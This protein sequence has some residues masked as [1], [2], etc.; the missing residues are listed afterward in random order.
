MRKILVL[1]ATVLLFSFSACGGGGVKDNTKDRD[2]KTEREE[3]KKGNDSGS[4][5]QEASNLPRFDY[6]FNKEPIEF[7]TVD[8]LLNSA[9]VYA[10]VTYTP[11]MF[12][13][14]YRLENE[15]EQLEKYMAEMDYMEYANAGYGEITSIP[16]RMEIGPKNYNHMIQY[17]SEY[18]WARI[19]FMNGGGN[20]ESVM[21]AYT[22]EGNLI[23][24]SPVVEYN[25][26]KEKNK[27]S[28]RLSDTAWEYEFS[29]KGPDLTLSQNGKSITMRAED[30]LEGKD[31]NISNYLNDNSSKIEGMDGISLSEY[32]NSIIVLHRGYENYYDVIGGMTNDGLFVISWI[33]ENGVKQTKQFVYFYCDTD[34][35][36]LSDGNHNYYFNSSYYDIYTNKLTENV[37]IE[38]KAALEKMDE[39]EL[40]EI[41]EKKANL[42]D[43][44]AAAYEAS[45]LNVQI[46]RE[47][48]EIELD[49]TILF[50]V[51]EFE[52]SAEGKEFL[53]KFVDVYTSVV[54]DEKYE[55]FVSMVMIEG[56]TDTNGSYERNLQLSQDRADSVMTFCTSAESGLDGADIEALKASAKAVGY[57]YDKPVYDAEGNVDMDASRRVSFRFIINLDK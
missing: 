10:K 38:D 21:A 26:D 56:H 37:S 43:D 20:M 22:V 30:F 3:G 31:L 49:S 7:G 52:V 45:G 9:E 28:Y 14:C 18:N 39:E 47:T 17:V 11:E 6:L 57:S 5:E 15:E 29:F 40:Q 41:I 48:G 19:Y 13:G 25:Y 23:R 27:I 42:L 12:F 55:G 24:F 4:A 44:L 2:V 50:A 51:N 32:S 54:F 53:K 36:V 16:Y 8:Q 46:N 1:L 34:G 33:D 35:I